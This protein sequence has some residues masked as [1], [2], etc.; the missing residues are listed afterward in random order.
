M[1]NNTCRRLAGSWMEFKWLSYQRIMASFQWSVYNSPTDAELV[2]IH[3]DPYWKFIRARPTMNDHIII[4][5]SLQSSLLCSQ[6]LTSVSFWT[7]SAF[8]STSA[9]CCQTQLQFKSKLTFSWLVLIPASLQTNLIQVVFKVLLD[10]FLI[11]SPL[12]VVMMIRC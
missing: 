8:K 9:I 3:I 7:S 1:K 6:L 5:R 4:A 12:S 10:F 11:L 2:D